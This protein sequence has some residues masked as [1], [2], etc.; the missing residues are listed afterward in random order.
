MRAKKKTAPSVVTL[1]H[2]S[3]ARKLTDAFEFKT[4][5]LGLRQVYFEFSLIVSP[6]HSPLS[7]T[8]RFR[9]LR[10]T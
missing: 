8:V 4:M 3:N 6:Y 2:N 9:V 7:L 5:G 1:C 10:S